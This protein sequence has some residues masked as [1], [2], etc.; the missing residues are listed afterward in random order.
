MG[1]YEPT[2]PLVRNH[3]LGLGSVVQTRPSFPFSLPAPIHISPTRQAHL[4]EINLVPELLFLSAAFLEAAVSAEKAVSLSSIF[5]YAWL[6]FRCF[7]FQCWA[8]SAVPAPGS[9][10]VFGLA[11]FPGTTFSRS[12]G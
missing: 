8:V 11:S 4:P 9:V 1:A 7:P 10:F 5:C 6:G 12:L 3:S 2:A